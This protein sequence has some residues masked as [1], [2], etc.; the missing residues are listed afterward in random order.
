M[1][2]GM[3][4][5][6]TMGRALCAV[7]VLG[8]AGAKTA[9]ADD[10]GNNKQVDVM[11]EGGIGGFTGN[12]AGLTEAGPTWGVAIGFQ[13]LTMIGFEIGYA[14]SRNVAS[15]G[16]ADGSSQNDVT[17]TRNGVDGLLKLSPPYMH[18]VKPFVGAGMGVSHVSK[19]GTGGPFQSDTM[20]EVPL[21]A[22]IELFSENFT[23]GLRGTYRVLVDNQLT[24]TTQ[25]SPN[26]LFDAS[27]TLGGRF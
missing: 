3:T 13:P 27:V 6:A 18:K 25:A 19:T 1:L 4:G 5:A 9:W 17:L 15:A 8:L 12:L 10:E 2:S 20:E 26:G 14:G 23:A 24:T 22:G 21:A 7:I 11:L 16:G